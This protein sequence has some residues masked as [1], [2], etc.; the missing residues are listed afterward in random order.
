MMFFAAS[1]FLNTLREQQGKL[2]RTGT[3][4][5][6]SDKGATPDKS[7]STVGLVEEQK[8]GAEE[9]GGTTG[10]AM[11]K[12]GAGNDA[13]NGARV[14]LSSW[15]RDGLRP[16]LE[17]C[18]AWM[19]EEEEGEGG[20]SDEEG[21]PEEWNLAAASAGCADV[22][23]ML[24]ELD[25]RVSALGEEATADSPSTSAGKAADTAIP[26]DSNPPM[27]A[28]TDGSTNISSDGSVDGSGRTR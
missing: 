2:E 28:G 23:A 10:S 20:S 6:R 26:P 3:N 12:N 22:N 15:E 21:V 18:R 9:A 14:S 27:V 24:S 16:L 8:H 5:P 4:I 11:P 1:N 19:K 25:R 17:A 13:E 7:S